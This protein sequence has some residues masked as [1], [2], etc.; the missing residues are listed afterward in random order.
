MLLE[1]MHSF[2]IKKK[3]LFNFNTLIDPLLDT[4]MHEWLCHTAK[5][6]LINI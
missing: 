5:N 6:F 1:V 3:Q 4:G 2:P